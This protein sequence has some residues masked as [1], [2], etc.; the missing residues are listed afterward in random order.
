MEGSVMLDS[1]IKIEQSWARKL[2]ESYDGRGLRE[3]RK[4]P[5][6][7]LWITNGNHF[8][9]GKD[10]INAIKLRCQ[11]D[12]EHLEGDVKIVR[13]EVAVMQWKH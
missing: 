4:V 1:K 5:Q 7:H 13:A 11:Q 3:S 6:Q 8:L 12:P 9:S 10:Y 2:Y